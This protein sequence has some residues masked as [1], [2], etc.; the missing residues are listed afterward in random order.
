M[1]TIPVKISGIGHY[2]PKRI[3][4]SSEIEERCKLRPGWIAQRTGVEE[5]RWVNGEDNSCMAAVAVRE[6][7]ADAGLD[8]TDVDLILNASGTSE[9]A[10]PDTAALIQRK[11]GLGESGIPC[12]SI[13]NTCL[14]FLVALDFAST[15]IQCGRHKNIVVCSADISS[16]ALNFDEP[17]SASLFGDGAGA[18]VLTRTPGNESSCIHTFRLE[19]YGVGSHLTEIRGG[20]TRRHPQ[21]SRTT[22]QD[23]LF[24]MNGPAVYKLAR[25]HID[26]FLEGLQKGLSKDPGDIDHVI[27]H[28]ASILALRAL[29]RNGISDDQVVITLDR[30]GN[31]VASS[32]PLTLHE[33]ITSNRLKRGEKVLLAGTGAGLSIAGMILTY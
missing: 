27:P 28:Q 24:H 32:L 18:V 14:S 8:L 29:R 25:K 23:N 10:I 5:R 6:A 30:Y 26:G 19:T 16:R 12:T 31:C 4:P 2:L 11:L 3:V 20:G 13:H 1:M 9:Q 7:V 33:A 17:E 15:L 22:P 21:D